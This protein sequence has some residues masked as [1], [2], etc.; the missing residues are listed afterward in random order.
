M[1]SLGI[2]KICIFGLG[3]MGVGVSLY[4]LSADKTVLAAAPDKSDLEF[5]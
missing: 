1:F 2:K 3:V 5:A 4:L